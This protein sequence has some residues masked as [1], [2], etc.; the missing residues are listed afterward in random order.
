MRTR[1]RQGQAMTTSTQA[2]ARH[3]MHV[4]VKSYFDKVR[5]WLSG[6]EFSKQL[7][8]DLALTEANDVWRSPSLPQASASPDR[9][10][11]APHR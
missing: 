3:I 7:E 4:R 11:P 6:V 9:S 1:I 8:I 10:T 2:N 5:I